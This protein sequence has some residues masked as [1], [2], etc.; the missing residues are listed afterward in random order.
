MKIRTYE[1]DNSI[2]LTDKLT[3]TDA[4]DA[5]KTKNYTFQKIKDFLIAEGLGGGADVS[6]KVDKVIG[7]SLILDTEIAIFMAI[8]QQLQHS[9]IIDCTLKAV[10]LMTLQFLLIVHLVMILRF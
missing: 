7:K 9:N 10:I 1:N 4:G 2:S 6:T 3:G 5:N 8:R